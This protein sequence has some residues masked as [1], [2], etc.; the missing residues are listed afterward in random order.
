MNY[1]GMQR[2]IVELF[3][4][5]A[6]IHRS[7]QGRTASSELWIHALRRERAKESEE[8]WRAKQTPDGMRKIWRRQQRASR[9]TR[10]T[11]GT[12]GPYRCKR[13]GELGHIARGCEATSRE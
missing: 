5:S 2:D 10:R 7:W 1:F 9:A 8:L 13:C 3:A 6:R 12:R 4:E 11:D